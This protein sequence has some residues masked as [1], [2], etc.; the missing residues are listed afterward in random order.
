LRHLASRMTGIQLAS[1]HGPSS[2]FTL[3]TIQSLW[4]IVQQS[5]DF[6]GRWSYPTRVPSLSIEHFIVH[7]NLYRRCLRSHK[8]IGV[9]ERRYWTV[10]HDQARLSLSRN[11]GCYLTIR[12]W[13][14]EPEGNRQTDLWPQDTEMRLALRVSVKAL[15]RTVHS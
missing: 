5:D 13:L 2:E 8:V 4:V 14:T 3:R 12:N 7:F 6:Q 9:Q 15:S 11:P 1:D 10:E